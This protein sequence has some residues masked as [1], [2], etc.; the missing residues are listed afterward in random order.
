MTRAVP[1][2]SGPTIAND[3]Q[4]CRAITGLTASAA[5]MVREFEEEE[6]EEESEATLSLQNRGT[7]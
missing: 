5:Q 4:K 2:G 6:E 1:P 7:N 3:R